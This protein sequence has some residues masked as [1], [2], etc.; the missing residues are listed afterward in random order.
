MY[1][2]LQVT[3]DFLVI[4]K[5]P[6][7]DFHKGS[8]QVGL[9]EKIRQD[10]NLVELFPLHRLDSMTSGIL[11]FAKNRTIA[12][13]ISQLFRE[14]KIEKFYLALS[15]GTPKKK[16]GTIKGDMSR[17]RNGGWILSHSMNRPAITQFFSAGLGNGLRLYIL[18]PC[19][20]KTHQLRV[21]MKS[22]GVPILG[23]PGYYTV[24]KNSAFLID[25]GYLHAFAIRF[26]LREQSYSFLDLPN[27]GIHFQSD[28]F[29]ALIERFLE[30]WKLEWP[31]V[32]NMIDG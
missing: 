18:K 8:A 13:E 10:L 19:T 27:S 16:Q 28:Q 25:R 24:S 21:M 1:K 22:H 11:M 9:V 15:P 6:G 12:Q 14:R 7:I 5:H 2:L 30:P 3:N 26:T 23:D 32:K 4:S 31:K 20:G 17:G 29:L